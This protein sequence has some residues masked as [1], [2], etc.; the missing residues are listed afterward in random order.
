MIN[1]AISGFAAT[2]SILLLIEQNKTYHQR[3]QIKDLKAQIKLERTAYEERTRRLKAAHAKEMA[4][5]HDAV[6]SLQTA[7]FY[8]DEKI[9]DLYAKNARQSQI[10]RQKWQTAKG[11]ANDRPL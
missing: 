1:I 2:V 8:R 5:S 10:I 3:K 6:V 7:L 11:T 4:K 9:S